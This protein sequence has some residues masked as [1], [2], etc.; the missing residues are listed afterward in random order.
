MRNGILLFWVIY[1]SLL[2]LKAGDNSFMKKV[3]YLLCFLILT[4]CTTKNTQKFPSK[5][6]S[7]HI[8]YIPSSPKQESP[9][10][11]I[12]E[13]GIPYFNGLPLLKYDI[14][15]SPE[16]LA[17][18]QAYLRWIGKGGVAERYSDLIDRSFLPEMIDKLS[19]QEASRL[20]L[21][22]DGP[23]SSVYEG[24]PETVQSALCQ[25]GFEELILDYF[26]SAGITPEELLSLNSE[27][28]ERLRM[29]YTPIEDVD[30]KLES[31][32]FTY[33]RRTCLSL[34]Q[35]LSLVFEQ[36]DDDVFRLKANE[37]GIPHW[38]QDALLARGHLRNEILQMTK[39]QQ[40]EALVPAAN[41]IWYHPHQSY[42]PIGFWD[43]TETG[44]VY[45]RKKGRD[46]SWDM[47]KRFFAIG[48]DTY[49]LVVM[50]DEEWNMLF[51]LEE[52][53][54]KLNSL[55]F[56]DQ[57]IAASEGHLDWIVKEAIRRN[58]IF[59]EQSSLTIGD[60]IPIN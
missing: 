17:Y 20:F 52:L 55:G 35:Q 53:P 24:L 56:S 40:D 45:M 26:L 58:Q 23:G 33:G 54:A 22:P 32:G 14:T 12:K 51:P 4:G 11:I 59:F 9:L 2:I 50:T 3:I 13:D 31:M 43:L 28:L 27:Q 25:L 7:L 16:M 38:K 19:P 39:E 36:P 49:E 46:M 15:A 8:D 42:M 5:S 44:E 34:K 48:Y 30:E 18:E 1:H 10:F 21:I 41:I 47:R 57:E 29:I 6:N 37:L 60:R